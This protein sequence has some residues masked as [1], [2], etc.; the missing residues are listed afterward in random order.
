MSTWRRAL[1]GA[2]SAPFAGPAGQEGANDQR[3]DRCKERQAIGILKALDA[4]SAGI[5]QGG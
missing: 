1:H 2:T 4:L 5:L 3:A